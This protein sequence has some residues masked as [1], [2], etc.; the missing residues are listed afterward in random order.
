VIGGAHQRTH[1][2]QAL[3]DV[4]QLGERLDFPRQVI[5]PDGAAAGEAGAGLGTDLEQAEVV[6][7]GATRGI[8]EG[9]TRHLVVDAE[10]E[11]LLVELHR[12]IDVADVEDGVVESL[13]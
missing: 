7:V 6:V 11:G 5:E 3:A 1:A 4:L 10:A 12:A 13:H 9:G 8:E 2:A